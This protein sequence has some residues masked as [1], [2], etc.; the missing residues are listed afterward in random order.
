[1]NILVSGAAAR[2]VFIEGE[3]LFYVD[4]DSLGELKSARI[5]DL[6][7]LLGDAADTLELQSAAKED[8]LSLL[9]ELWSQDRALRMLQIALDPIEDIDTVTLAIESLDAFLDD[10]TVEEHVSNI[11]FAWPISPEPEMARLQAI[12]KEHPNVEHLLSS[13]ASTQDLISR[14]RRGWE[15]ISIRHFE[16]PSDKPRIESNA[17]KGGLFRE[18]VFAT[19]D[20]SKTDRAVFQC[21]VALARVNGYRNIV[22]AWIKNIGIHPG[23]KV[24]DDIVL[25]MKSEREFEEAV[26]EIEV[27]DAGDIY[28][29]VRGSQRGIVNRL[30][31]GDLA[32]AR[33][34]ANEL[35]EYQVSHGGSKFAAKSLCA[36]AQEAKKL[37]YAS[38]QLEWVTAATK[39]APSDAWAHGQAGDAYFEIYRFADAERSY[40][41]ASVLGDEQ[42]GLVGRGRLWRAAGRLDDALELFKSAQDRFPAHSEAYR[43]WVGIAETLRDMGRLDEALEVYSTTIDKFPHEAVVWCGH[44]AVL[45]DLGR[46]DD[47]DIC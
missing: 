21:Y 18:L 23:Q 40:G 37:G 8:G 39:V 36:L 45:R 20:N 15:N 27:G 35:V 31:R 10:D 22:T 44:A 38:L 19:A 30:A 29:Q 42:F 33:K 25:D 9:N 4:A 11:A 13:V 41:Q 6:P 7:N 1:M 26:R 12:L 43:A 34:Y 46:L 2:A 5:S 16:S 32:N 17:V 3:D 28:E 47:A 24:G 14:V